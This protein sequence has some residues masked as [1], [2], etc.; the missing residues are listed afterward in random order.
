MMLARVVPAR[1]T[2]IVGLILGVLTI[3]AVPGAL[4]TGLRLAVV[5]AFAC[6]GPGLAII[7]FARSRDHA[8]NAAMVLLLSLATTAVIGTVLLWWRWWNPVAGGVVLAALVVA[9]CAA[10]LVIDRRRPF[11]RPVMP[12]VD[13]TDLI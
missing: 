13:T 12:R 2:A 7:T 9:A 10:A 3:I 4:P 11:R 8:V 1:P 5:L 6:A